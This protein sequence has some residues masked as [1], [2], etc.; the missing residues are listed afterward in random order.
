MAE[1]TLT[2]CCT[3]LTSCLQPKKVCDNSTVYI[4]HHSS[5]K[6]GFMLDNIC[7][8]D[9]D[10]YDNSDSIS[11]DSVKGKLQRENSAAWHKGNASIQL[12]CCCWRPPVVDIWQ[13]ADCRRHV[14]FHMLY[15]SATMPLMSGYVASQQEGPLGLFPS[16]SDCE[17]SCEYSEY[18]ICCSVRIGCCVCCVSFFF[19]LLCF[20]GDLQDKFLPGGH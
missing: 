5:Y 16:Q 3:S 12:C 9:T 4:L 2:S 8:F 20:Y 15:R 13:L 7:A 11:I 18:I 17:C 6:I 14:I 19:P 1:N 10:I